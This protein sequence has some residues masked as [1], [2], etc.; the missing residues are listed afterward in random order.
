[1][2]VCSCSQSVPA[3]N[4]HPGHRAATPVRLAVG[5]VRQH[6]GLRT[7]GDERARRLEAF[8]T[9]GQRLQCCS[10][11]GSLPPL[12]TCGWSWRGGRAGSPCKGVRHHLGAAQYCEENPPPDKSD[13]QPGGRLGSL[14]D[15]VAEQSLTWLMC[16]CVH[17]HV[18]FVCFTDLRYRMEHLKGSIVT[19]RKK[20]NIPVFLMR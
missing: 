6:A 1:M 9:L 4:H 3:D 11:S 20:K 8:P 19:K 12:Y 2:A 5:G 15:E 17:G 7:W 14:E 13:N 18:Q 16:V 10:L